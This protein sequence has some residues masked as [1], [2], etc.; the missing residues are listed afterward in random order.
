M[1]DIPFKGIAMAAA[2]S[3]GAL[4]ISNPAEA[5]SNVPAII[6]GVAAGAIIAGAVTRHNRPYYNHHRPYYGHH[7]SYYYAP[8]PHYYAPP[9]TVVY[10]YAPPPWTGEWYAYCA[11]RYRSFDAR[12]GTFQ[13]YYGPR[14]L[15]R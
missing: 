14:R 6:A 12:S 2:L 9:P 15:C 3:V 5:R 13:P 4:A 8:A 10:S 1:P 7:S 11:Q